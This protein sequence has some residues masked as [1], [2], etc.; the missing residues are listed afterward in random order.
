MKSRRPALSPDSGAQNRRASL[1][2]RHRRR[3]L[4]HHRL[5]QRSHRRP[6]ASGEAAQG[7]PL[8]R[9]HK[10]LPPPAQPSLRHSS[11]G[12][13]A[14]P[15]VYPTPAKSRHHRHRHQHLQLLRDHRWRRTTAG[16][17]RGDRPGSRGSRR[18]AD[19]GPRLTIFL[20][21]PS[22]ACV[23]SILTPSASCSPP[24]NLPSS[25]AW[26]QRQTG[27][28]QNTASPHI[29]HSRQQ[30]ATAPTMGATR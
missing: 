25:E 30:S 7:S 14:S 17:R 6:S 23:R 9:R 16:P 21:S 10:L 13:H 12:G 1:T 8:T 5:A 27:S 15:H 26:Y 18:P 11:G 22:I 28:R 2:P 19:H 4:R 3:L 29:V 20:R 24:V